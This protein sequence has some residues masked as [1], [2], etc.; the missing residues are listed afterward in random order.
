[1]EINSAARSRTADMSENLTS[2]RLF[3]RVA[4]TGSFS[5][6]AREFGIPQPSV[7]RAI[8]TLERSLGVALFVRS[9]RAIVLSDAGHDYMARIEPILTALDEANQTVKGNG[10]L[11]GHLRV[12]LPPGIAIREVIPRIPEFMAQHPDLHIEL[13]MDDRR[14][15]L[16][17]EGLDVAIRLGELADSGLI[18]RTVGSTKRMLVAS[19]K[20]LK[21]RGA[22]K[23][24]ADLVNHTVIMGPPGASMRGWTFERNGRTSSIKVQ[25]NLVTSV[26]EGAT[27][28]AVAGL[29]I[30]STADLGCRRELEEGLLVQILTEWTMP[31]E[32]ISA[33]FPAGNLTKPASRTFVQFLIDVLGGDPGVDGR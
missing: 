2:L 7:S 19:P 24:P 13:M 31:V 25:S 12:G 1:M 26:N 17:K 33:V 30:I 14:L 27:V 15:D 5:K 6:A 4:R 23:S 3:I 29:G 18:A 10:E 11:R 8:A 9:T 16:L 20:Y 22:P 32:T 28:A 21:L